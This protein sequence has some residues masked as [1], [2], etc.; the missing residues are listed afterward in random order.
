MVKIRLRKNI[1]ESCYLV[2]SSVAAIDPGSLKEDDFNN[3]D[4]KPDIDTSSV[5]NKRTITGVDVNGKEVTINMEKLIFMSSQIISSS[6]VKRDKNLS[7]IMD[8]WNKPIIWSVNSETACTDGYRLFFNPFFANM[9]ILNDLMAAA[10]KKNNP[11]L[12]KASKTYIFVM[13]HEAYHI[14][15]DHMRIAK[16]LNADMRIFNI[17]A[18]AEINRD[19]ELQIPSLAGSTKEIHGIQIEKVLKDIGMVED[20]KDD[21]EYNYYRWKSSASELY[22]L[23]IKNANKLSNYQQQNNNQNQ[24]S[25]QDSGNQQGGNQGQGQGQDGDDPNTMDPDFIKGWNDAIKDYMSGKL[26]L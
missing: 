12:Q 7:M 4:N 24:P 11:T 17:A 2:E 9:L 21:S 15:Y 3:P 20:N 6:D 26:K 13:V 23:L 18:D 10:E 16:S 19:I 14:L 1:L 5:V 25:D 8:Y 22:E